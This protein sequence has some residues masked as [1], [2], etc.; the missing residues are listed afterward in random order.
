MLKMRLWNYY[1]ANQ[2]LNRFIEKG[3]KMMKKL[4][5]CLLLI[6][7]LSYADGLKS[8]DNFL[9][10]KTSTI[11]ANF[12]QTVFGN[13]KD[14]ISNGTME[15]ARPNKFKWQYASL[16]GVSGQLIMSDSKTIYVYDKDLAQVTEKKLTS[17]IDS[18]PALLLAGGSN[19]HEIYNV[20]SIPSADTLDWVSL[21]PKKVDDNNGFKKVEIGFNKID[22]KLAQMRFTD[23]FDN[24]SKIVFSNVNMNAKFAPTAFIFKAPS[25][26]DI[27]KSDN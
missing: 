9:K 11:S 1:N 18:S 22:G 4:L 23:S 3:T 6:T 16:N 2:S 14:R 7:A 10:N 15:I 24:K 5:P 17:S 21:I 26:T 27:I 8:I 13:R 12:T 25:G 20:T 19:V